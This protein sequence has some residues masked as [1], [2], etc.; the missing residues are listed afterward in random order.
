MTDDAAIWNVLKKFVPKRKWIPLQEIV[1]MVRTRMLLDHED[2]QR[3][4]SASGLPRWES[5][6]RR[7][8][9][10]KARIGSIRSRKRRTDQPL[11]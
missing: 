7:L 5:N 10:A 9:R 3:R 2:L 11:P 6:V 4:G 8:L 1:S